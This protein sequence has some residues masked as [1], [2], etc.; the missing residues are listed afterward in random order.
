MIRYYLAAGLL[1]QREESGQ[2]YQRLV[3]LARRSVPP[4]A[5][6][7]PCDEFWRRWRAADGERR[8]M[9]R[10]Q[11]WPALA[12]LC[13]AF[14]FITAED[15]SIG[16]GVRQ[17]HRV[18]HRAGH[19]CFWLTAEGE[20]IPRGG[21]EIVRLQKAR[22][23]RAYVVKRSQPTAHEPEREQTEQREEVSTHVP[24]ATRTPGRRS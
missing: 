11:W 1:A 12:Q 20:L 16:D 10:E 15:G 3:Q 4:G 24:V 9:P 19:P 13:D 5:E 23:D 22:P 2:R 18:M 21:Y 7:V 8:Q 6:V 14:V 17:E